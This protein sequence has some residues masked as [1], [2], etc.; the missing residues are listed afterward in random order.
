MKTDP[1]MDMDMGRGMS[2]ERIIAHVRGFDGS[3]VVLPEA[4][5]GF[6]ELVWGDAFFSYSPDGPPP[7]TLQPYGTIVTKDYPGD[8][9]SALGPGRWRVNVHVER[10]VFRELT[11]EEPRDLRLPR[12]PAAADTLV[13]HPVYGQLGWVCVVNPGARTAGTVLRLLRG[14]HEAARARASRRRAGGAP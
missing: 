13:P 3:H 12:D 2:R 10:A 5:G 14:A 8:A 9:A 7:P 6:P 4:G 1:S 11:G